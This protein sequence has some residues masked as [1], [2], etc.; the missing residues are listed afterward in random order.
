MEKGFM[1][2]ITFSKVEDPKFISGHGAGEC[3]GSARAAATVVCV[4][5][6]QGK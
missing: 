2:F 5:F 3:K 1:V 6:T 4:R